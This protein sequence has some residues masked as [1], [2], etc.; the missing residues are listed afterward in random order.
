MTLRDCTLFLQVPKEL[1]SDPTSAVE[2]DSLSAEEAA[3]SATNLDSSQLSRGIRIVIADLDEKSES[4]RGEYW[5]SLEDELISG[6]YYLGKGKLDAKAEDCDLS[7]NV[8]TS[9]Q[10]KW[11]GFTD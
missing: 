6:G 11:N 1:I 10:V 7:D 3:A 5:Q 4:T 9:D 8:W 2:I